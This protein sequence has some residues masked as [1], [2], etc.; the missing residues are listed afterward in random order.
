MSLRPSAT[1]SKPETQPPPC[2]VERM[3]FAQH[4]SCLV[5]NLDYQTPLNDA[6]PLPPN[7]AAV[8][9]LDRII[10]ARLGMSEKSVPA[11]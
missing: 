4:M 10:R 6:D 5:F 7:R 11:R 3:E 1:F 2:R 8:I 9:E